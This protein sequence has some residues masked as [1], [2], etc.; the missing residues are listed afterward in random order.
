MESLTM[1][2]ADRLVAAGPQYTLGQVSETMAV[3]TPALSM[4]VMRKS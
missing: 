3:S 1:R 2:A 4:L